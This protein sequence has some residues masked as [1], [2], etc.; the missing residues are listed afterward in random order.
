MD[1]AGTFL[2]FFEVESGEM[3]SKHRLVLMES[4][5]KMIT[6]SKALAINL[7]QYEAAVTE[8]KLCEDNLGNLKY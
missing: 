1:S 5:L 7:K 6:L 2:D 3:H 4:L 8:R